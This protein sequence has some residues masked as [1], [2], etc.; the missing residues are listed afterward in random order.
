MLRRRLRVARNAAALGPA[1]AAGR[2][3]ASTSPAVTHG[4][5]GGEEETPPPPEPARKVTGTGRGSRRRAAAAP[6]SAGGRAAGGRGGPARRC[7][8][9]S[10]RRS[11]RRRGGAAVMSRGPGSRAG[12]TRS[13]PPPRVPRDAKAPGGGDSR[14]VGPRGA[15]SPLPRRTRRPHRPPARPQLSP[16]RR[17]KTSS[18][19]RTI[20]KQVPQEQRAFSFR[21][22]P[23]P[24]STRQELPQWCGIGKQRKKKKKNAASCCPTD[25]KHNSV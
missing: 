22:E 1:Q 18:N 21:R 10:R 9:R 2:D 6:R 7:S 25:R 3:S 11:S 16:Q 8:R 13:A 4:P 12:A 20:P 5:A 19:N 15:Q 24:S 23:F 14:A 17:S